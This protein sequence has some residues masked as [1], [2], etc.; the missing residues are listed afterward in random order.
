VLVE[1][2]GL[3]RPGRPLGELLIDESRGLSWQQT[4]LRMVDRF[5]G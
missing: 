1:A 2:L 4:P 5:I 3:P